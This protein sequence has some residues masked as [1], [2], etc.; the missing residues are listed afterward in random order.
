VDEW[1]HTLRNRLNRQFP[2]LGIPG[3]T[4]AFRPTYDIDIPWCYQHKDRLIQWGGIGKDLLNGRWARLSER[5]KVLAGSLADPFD[6]FD[7]MDEANLGQPWQP[8]YFFPLSHRRTLYDKNPSPGKEA[9]RE[10]I[11]RHDTL[12]PVGIHPSFYSTHHPGQVQKEIHELAALLDRPVTLNRFHYVRFR[13]PEDYRLLL[14]NRISTDYSMGYG[15]RNGF[16]A[17]YSRPFRWYDLQKEEETPLTVVPFCCMDATGYSRWG[18]EQ[19]KALAEI[20]GYLR[21][22]RTVQ[23]QLC[24]IWHNNSLGET[25]HWIG[26]RR[27]YGE[28]LQK[29][30]NTAPTL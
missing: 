9:Y 10:L 23:G 4:F 25:P 11:R 5:R 6:N 3:G 21:T 1:I 20:D 16:R 28:L 8:V 30:K 15:E 12:Y 29:V 19:E 17:S 13:L 22:L 26:W 14:K 2:A 7:W 27:L 18:D 24:V